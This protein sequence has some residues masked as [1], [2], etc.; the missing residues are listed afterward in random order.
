MDGI[1]L[2]GFQSARAIITKYTIIIPFS[3]LMGIS[4]H[5]KT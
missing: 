5:T 2:A 1:F 3:E 4:A